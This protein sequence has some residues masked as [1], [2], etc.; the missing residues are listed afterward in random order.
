MNQTSG[1]IG[2]HM[3]IFQESSIDDLGGYV[4]YAPIDKLDAYMIVNGCDS[5][6][7]L[8]LPSG[9]TISRDG[10]EGNEGS[11]L[12]MCFQVL[13]D[14]EGSSS[15]VRKKT[16]ESIDSSCMLMLQ[17]IKDALHCSDY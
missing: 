6:K 1:I 15:Q 7:K 14:E 5:S 16:L 13:V 10:R 4:V 17:R 11:L 3:V 8:I 9:F 12:T 2:E